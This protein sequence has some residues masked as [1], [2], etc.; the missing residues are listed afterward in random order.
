MYNVE[1]KECKGSIKQISV[2]MTSG[3]DIEAFADN[4]KRSNY[5]R[6]L[7]GLYEKRYITIFS[8]NN[9]AILIDKLSRNFDNSIILSQINIKEIIFYSNRR[10]TEAVNGSCSQLYK[11]NILYDN[12][13]NEFLGR[14]SD[15]KRSELS[16]ESIKLIRHLRYTESLSD[17]INFRSPQGANYHDS[18]RFENC[19]ILFENKSEWVYLNGIIVK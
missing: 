19:A 3:N 2:K 16:E 5:K 7:D 9:N 15:R 12:L 17:E 18:Y 14:V 1:I 10:I 13:M 8:P 6:M 4:I 11:E